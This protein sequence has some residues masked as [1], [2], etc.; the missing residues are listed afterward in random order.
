MRRITNAALLTLTTLA[1]ATC[2][3][4]PDHPVS[5]EELRTMIARFAPTVITA[6]TRGL[7]EGDRAA[8][9]VLV[10]ASAIMDSLILRQVWAGNVA[11]E[12]RLAQDSSED[13]RL[14]YRYFQINLGPWSS[15]DHGSAFVS[16]APPHHPLYANY[17]PEDLTREEFN[18]WVET[19]SAQDQARARGYFTTIRRGAD[20]SLKIVPYS[21]EY[22]EFLSEAARLLEEAA[23]LTDNA[24]LR[25]YLEKRARAFLTDDYYESDVAWM[26]LD[27][28]IDVTIGPV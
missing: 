23:H 22:A 11:M 13:G 1:F 26:L 6:D 14:R 20:G 21:E 28:P 2:A 18:R 8:L 19:L 25:D 16:G 24:S 4:G 15:L 3:R 17:Y 12:Y 5:T 9:G 7:S 10:K 27:S